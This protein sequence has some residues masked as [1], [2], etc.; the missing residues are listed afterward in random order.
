[1]PNLVECNIAKGGWKFVKS[2][3]S[4][5]YIANMY[6]QSA[7][8]ATASLSSQNGQTVTVEVKTRAVC[9]L[10]LLKFELFELYPGV[11]ECPILLL[12]KGHQV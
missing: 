6:I 8:D 7:L 3:S 1:M 10:G 4:P 2:S 12:R 11:I 5:S 9:I